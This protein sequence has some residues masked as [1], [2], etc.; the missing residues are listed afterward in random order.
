MNLDKLDKVDTSALDNAPDLPDLVYEDPNDI[1]TPS[2]PDVTN[3][4]DDVT[5]E[6]DDTDTESNETKDDIAEIDST[7]EDNTEDIDNTNK[8]EDDNVEI[9]STEDVN[10]ND[11]I[12]IDFGD[13]KIEADSID[14]LKTIASKALKDKNKYDKYKNELSILEGIKEQGLSDDDLYLLVEAKK[15]NKQAIAKL[16]KETNIDP[17]DLDL[18]D[19]S[20]DQYKP[21]EYKVDPKIM[22]VKSIIDDAKKDDHV[23]KTFDY[24]LNK[25]FSEKDRATAFE[26]PELLGFIKD[27]I[28]DGIFD[29]IAPNYT[30]RKIMGENPISAYIN[31]FKDYTSEVDKLASKTVSKAQEENKVKTEKRKKASVGNK[32]NV[33]KTDKKSVNDMTDE[34]FEEYYKS[35][36]GD[37]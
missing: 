37:F 9:R 30:K 32:K 35:V 10:N 12:L 1:D 6:N 23:F 28:R 3:N 21:K 4:N 17:Y 33:A 5:V 8:E 22:E 7:L 27:T 16:L 26:D 19:E 20:V 11:K 13:G 14:E 29:K 34:E 36:V 24:V 2:E 18:E 31:A 15:G 25:E